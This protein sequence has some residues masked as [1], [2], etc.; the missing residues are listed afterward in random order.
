MFNVIIRRYS[1]VCRFIS[2]HFICDFSNDCFLMRF[3]VLNYFV[4]SLI[5]KLQSVE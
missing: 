1:F 2:L 4:K 5:L 3:S